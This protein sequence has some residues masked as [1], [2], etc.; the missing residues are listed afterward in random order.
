MS[1]ES[2][3]YA[4]KIASAF[5]KGTL[6]A[7]L[8]IKFTKKSSEANK[9]RT[10]CEKLIT[11]PVIGFKAGGTGKPM[12]KKLGEREPFC[13][14]I[15]KKNL[16][17]SNGSVKIN[18]YTLG[19]ELEVFYQVK[20]SFFSN[21]KKITEKN[22]SS[23][24]SHMGPC[25]EVV[26]YRQKKKGLTYLGDLISDFGANVKFIIGKKQKFKKLKFNN[27]ATSLY[28]KK[29]GQVA[30]GNTKT[31]YDSHLKSLIWLLNKIKKNKIDLNKDFLVFTGSTVGVVPIQKTGLFKGEIKSLGSVKTK[32]KN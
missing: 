9:F 18:K 30:N 14:A 2:T 3:R 20:K 26:G 25:I 16:L 12:L 10:E 27:L 4:K 22:V 5:N 19:I 13:A 29:S 32:I 6:I 21:S 8:P 17:K 1:L 28:N 15:F 23:V 31:V 11:S 24:V 7:P